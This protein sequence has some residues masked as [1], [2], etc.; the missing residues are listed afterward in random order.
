MSHVFGRL[1]RPFSFEPLQIDPEIFASFAP[2][3]RWCTHLLKR[4]NSM[5]ALNTIGLFSSA[6]K[7]VGSSAAMD[8]RS[9]VF[10]VPLSPKITVQRA[11]LPLPSER[12]RVCFGP[13]QRTFSTLSDRKYAGGGALRGLRRRTSDLMS[14]EAL[15][16]GLVG[17]GSLLASVLAEYSREGMT[18]E[19]EML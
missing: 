6:S 16:L 2:A 13:K 14:G 11:G 5:N 15:L 8:W 17:T 3:P 9:V 10:P 19:R 7:L 18:V 4:P 12:S 1:V